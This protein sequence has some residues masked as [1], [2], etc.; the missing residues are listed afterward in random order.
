MSSFNIK[1]FESIDASNQSQV[2]IDALEKFNYTRQIQEL[3]Q[4]AK[5]K[6]KELDKATILD[7][8]CSPG[9]ES[10]KIALEF[11]NS[12]CRA[13]DI[14]SDFLESA[15]SKAQSSAPLEI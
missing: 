6:I 5:S 12:T 11:P 2:F 13:V 10:I 3:N 8:G 9:F 7:A 1:K 15:N 14:S 4:I